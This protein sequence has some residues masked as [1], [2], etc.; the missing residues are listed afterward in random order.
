MDSNTIRDFLKE[1]E[2][3][4]QLN[5]E[6]LGIELK[7]NGRDLVEMNRIIDNMEQTGEIIRTK[8]GKLG[9][10][11][12]MG[13]FTGKIQL[14][15]KGFGFLMQEKDEGKKTRDDVFIPPDKTKNAMNGDTV[16]VKVTTKEFRNVTKQEGEVVKIL[17][18][19]TKTVIGVYQE[20]PNFGFVLPEDKKIREDIFIPKGE[21]LNA[22]NNDVVVI[23]LTK[24][25]A[26]GKSAQGRV[27][28]V[29]GRKGEPGVDMLMVLT[30]FNLPQE[31]PQKVLDYVENIPESIQESELV[32]RR[33]LRSEIIVTIDGADAKDLDDAITVSRLENGNYK[34][35]VHIADVTHY[36]AE[37]SVLDEEALK[38]ATSVYLIDLVIP[39]LPQKLSNN[40]CSLNPHTDKLALSC[41]ME[42]DALG[43]VQ[44][45]EVFESVI[46]TTERMTYDD[47]NAILTDHDVELTEKYA[48]LVPM[49]NNMEHLF[50]ILNKKR[51]D[52]GSIDFDFTESY[53]ELNEKGEPIEVRPF[54]RGVS[55]RIIEEFMLAAN[56]T[57]AETYFG[58]HTPFVYRIHENPD[59]EKLQVFS[60][61]ASIMGTPIQFG[62]DIE[63]R[64]LQTV[65]AAVKGTDSE[66]V[67]S[68]LLLRSMM[69]A[70]YSPTNVGHFGLA[71]KYYCHFTSPIRRYPDLQI[72]RIIKEQ[73][74]GQLNAE[75]IDRLSEIVKRTSV[76]SSEMERVAEEAEREVDDMKKTQYMHAHLGEE[77]IGVI[78]SVTN[79]GFF[80]ELPNTIEGLVH[81][82]DLPQDFVYDDRRMILQS[83]G[84]GILA[85]GQKVKIIVAAVD[86]DNHEINFN[87]LGKV[88]PEGEYTER[89]DLHDERKPLLLGNFN[90]S[91][92]PRRNDKRN[93]QKA[94]PVKPA[95]KK[96]GFGRRKSEARGKKKK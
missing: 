79:F 41:E 51:M 46:K 62:K 94:G 55:N 19:N 33:D 8:K 91:Q 52:R 42:I 54:V 45:S 67:L 86:V 92:K 57:V 40:L 81:I 93:S 38:R 13:F 87:F 59:P 78:S 16:L 76:I 61:M 24:Y 47:V 58:L 1:R 28:S 18:R 48:H 60:E 31:F 37:D 30:K 17:S 22:K 29:L 75:E 82:S 10:P 68:K 4:K 71:A 39:M 5:A 11:E 26:E 23:E 73:L 65:L 15:Q 88:S 2:S 96:K 21:N 27:I 34:L 7:L 36:V 63:P 9:L 49:F 90:K 83:D 72:H 53:I 64:D 25:P 80:V 89:K 32:R 14:H 12:D 50:E 44:H 84:H 69:Q 3:N 35:G 66:H 6:E 85:L 70:K 77:F 43:V 95:G 56:E 74:N 20:N